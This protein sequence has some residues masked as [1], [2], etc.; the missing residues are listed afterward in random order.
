MKTDEDK[1]YLKIV[2]LDKIYDFVVDTLL[3]EII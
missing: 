1:L 3:F 2:E